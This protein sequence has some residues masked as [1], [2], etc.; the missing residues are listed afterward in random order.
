MMQGVLMAELRYCLHGEI[1]RSNASQ[2]KEHL[3]GAVA[4]SGAGL[5][6]D[7][8]GLDFIDSSG[9]RVLVE[10]QRALAED[11]RSFRVIDASLILQRVCEAMGV[12]GFFDL[13]YAEPINIEMLA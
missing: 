6:V 4:G 10:T 11:G 3:A 12:T 2:L 1:D 5:V 7:C 8:S 13:G 9:I